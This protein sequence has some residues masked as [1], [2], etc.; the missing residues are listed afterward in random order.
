MSYKKISG[1]YTITNTVNNKI[2]V[3]ESKNIRNRISDHKSRLRGNYHDNSYLQRAWNKYGEI[4]FEFEILEE[5]EEKFLKSQEHYWCVLLDS[6]NKSKGYNL[7]PTHPEGKQI[8]SKQAIQG[9]K[10]FMLKNSPRKGRKHSEESK[11][12]MR[13]ARNLYL[14]TNLHNRLGKSPSLETRLK[15]SLKLRKPT[16]YE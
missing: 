5:C 13:N 3:G 11:K 4:N 14:K 6:A 8:I 12:R 1:I 16:N 15:I 7:N 10:T 9:L 2:L